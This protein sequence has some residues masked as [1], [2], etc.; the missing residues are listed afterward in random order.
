[1][2]ITEIIHDNESKTKDEGSEPSDIDSDI[3]H[4]DDYSEHVAVEVD[5]PGPGDL[6]S[7]TIGD[8]PN[9]VDVLQISVQYL[10]VKDEVEKRTFQSNWY[11]LYPWLYYSLEV[12]GVV[13]YHCVKANTF[14]LLSL[15][16][17]KEETFISKGF[18]YWKMP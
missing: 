7:I 16:R 13:C 11:K 1:M 14:N 8:K 6:R 5:K 15:N 2:N 9:H 17:N 3:M 18:R 10:R 12:H 4:N